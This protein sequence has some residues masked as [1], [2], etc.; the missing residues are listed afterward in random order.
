MECNYQILIR[1]IDDAL[2][3]FGTSSL[4]DG[5]RVR[6]NLLDLRSI[7][8]QYEIEILEIETV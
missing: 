1:M 8:S 3:E 5:R 6:D 4:V 7:C 2:A